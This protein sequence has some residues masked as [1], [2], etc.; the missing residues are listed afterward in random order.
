MAHECRHAHAF[1]S[2]VEVCQP[3]KP[4]CSGLLQLSGYIVNKMGVKEV[5]ELL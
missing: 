2:R 4:P 3:G 1:D 5:K